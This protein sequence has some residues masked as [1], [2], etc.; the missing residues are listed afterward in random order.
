MITINIIRVN[1][2]EYLNGKIGKEGYSIENTPEAKT[3]LLDFA[4]QYNSCTTLVDATKVLEDAKAY[5]ASRVS[6]SDTSLTE[7]L[8][9]DLMYN[10]K[11]NAYHIIS[12]GKTSVEPVHKFFSDKMIEANDKG[13]CP[14]PWLT[15]WVRLMRN[16]LY[17]HDKRKVKTLIKY[18]KAQYV[19]EENVNKLKEEGYSH[20]VA[21]QLSTFDQISITEEGILAAFKYVDLIDKKYVVKKDE[22]GEQ[23]IERV[24]M[25]ER[26]LEVDPITGEITK[27][28]LALPAFA[29]D[30]FFEPPIMRQGGNPFT[31]KE[32][33]DTNEDPTKGHVIKIGRVHELSAG[34]DQ[35]NTNDDTSCVPGLH[36]GKL[37]AA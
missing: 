14:K 19:D 25:Y 32:L 15:F 6:A 35:V 8:K 2:V 27:D 7:V 5:A 20:D 26:T 33:N 12:D 4:K 18:L 23:T 36:L 31:C 11:T 21:S 3:A 37:F 22:N 34:F 10:P 1:E 24:D 9:G 13:L 28:E 17:V 30:F 16:P 29:E